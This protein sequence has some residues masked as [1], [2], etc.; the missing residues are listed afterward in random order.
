MFVDLVGSTALSARLDP[1]DMREIIGAYHRCCA[2]QITKAGGFVAKYMGDGVLAYFGYPQAHEDDAERAVE[3]GLSLVHAVPMLRTGH[4]ATLQVRVGI[5]TG[6]VVVGD[7]IG[8]GDA[9]ERGVVGDTPNLASRLQ[10]FAEP[11][12][13]VISDATRRLTG[14]MFEYRDLGGVVLKGLSEAVR[15]WQVLGTSAVE[16]RFEAQHEIGLTP[17]VGREEELELLLR[18]WHR[19]KSGYGQVVLLSGEP[20]IGKSRLTV[21]LQERLQAEPHTRLRYFCSPHHQDS[22]LHPIVARLERAAGFTRD[23]APRMKL[24]KLTALLAPATPTEEDV[25]LLADLLSIQLTD[26][27]PPLNFSPQRK[28]E[29]TLEALFR[30]LEGLA[31]R[32]PVL[33]IFEDVHWIDPTSRE[34]LDFTIEQARR[35]PIL[36][37]VTF[38]SEF[39]PPWTGLPHVTVLTLNRLRHRDGAAL[40]E[41]I[42]GTRTALPHD[43]VEVIIERTDGIPLFLEELTKTV[44][45]GGG[46]IREPASPSSSAQISIPPTLHA[47]LMAR[48]DR[49]GSRAKKIAQVGAAIGREFSY[50]LMSRVAQESD[51]VLEASLKRLIDAGLVFCRGTPPHAILLFKHALVRDAAYESLLRGR[52]QQLHARIGGVIEECFPALAE[53]E[54]E[55]LAQHFSEANLAVKASAYRERAGDRAVARSAYAEAVA[56]YNAGLE[57]AGRLPEGL[58]RMRRE[59]GLLLKLGPTL[60]ITATPDMTGV[61][62]RAYGLAKNLG[63]GP[64]LFKATW[65]LWLDA[66]I[67]FRLDEAALRAEELTALSLRLD[68]EDLLLEADH[69]RWSTANYRGDMATVLKASRVGIERYNRTRHRRLGTQFLAGHDPGVCA[70]EVHGAALWHA[71]FVDQAMRHADQGI[72]LAETLNHPYSLAFALSSS[73]MTFQLTGDREKCRRVAKRIIEMDRKYDFPRGR[74][75]GIFISGWVGAAGSSCAEG[76]EM[77]EAEFAAFTR[78]HLRRFWLSALLAEARVEA[79]R[80]ADALA[81]LCQTLQHVVR[82]DIGYYL[83]EI[84]RLQGELL[85][86]SSQGAP[87]AE[88]C[89]H[90]A[91]QTARR[92]GTFSLQLRAATSLARL[93]R[94]Q[95]KRTEACDLLAPAYG[96]FTEG[97]DTPDLKEAKALLDELA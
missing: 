64:E 83:S 20:G 30:Q 68:D 85:L 61:Y 81:L 84:Y 78:D 36:L 45:E 75:L 79:G 21:A 28:K 52:R 8:E 24:E 11:G 62:H 72:A 86:A 1:G 27:H 23:D 13:V 65:G 80:L 41:R 69:C 38:R 58:E 51:D 25:A 94:D 53:V 95:G 87:S 57:E 17:M 60:F 26:R 92:Q 91:I 9:Q 12:Q 14:G 88:R 82:P 43:V 2:E 74:A 50:E 4:E 5:A 71:G 48:L 47:S 97:F 67:T 35:L 54:P 89:F 93:W 70:L 29:K 39:S 44:L 34:L 77:M 31:R 18:R 55:L 76:L 46:D 10:A 90:A 96:W 33:M 37:L 16:S 56:Q 6:L 22:P 7:L 49:L 3:G 66:A 15:S 59:I 40:V 73:I 42:I 19:A 63:D 32:Q